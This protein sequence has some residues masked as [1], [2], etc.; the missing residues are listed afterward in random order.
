MQLALSGLGKNALRERGRVADPLGTWGPHDDVELR[1]RAGHEPPVSTHALVEIQCGRPTARQPLREFAVWNEWKQPLRCPERHGRSAW[2]RTLERDLPEMHVGR[3]E[4]GVRRVV[5]IE[6]AHRWIAEQDA[7][8]AIRL[9]P[10][11]VRID[12]DG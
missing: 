11:L 4:I 9:Q 10:M 5:A 12:H 7:A 2:A 3:G 8:A 6:S 1:R